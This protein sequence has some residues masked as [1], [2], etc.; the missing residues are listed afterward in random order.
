MGGY[1]SGRERWRYCGIE[2]GGHCFTATVGFDEHDGDR[3]RRWTLRNL[4]QNTVRTV[5][6]VSADDPDGS[7][8][9]LQPYSP[10]SDQ[11]LDGAREEREATDDR[12]PR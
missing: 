2:V 5:S 4:L 6:T 10:A 8:D 9:S 7:G 3:P 1:R 11:D 12:A